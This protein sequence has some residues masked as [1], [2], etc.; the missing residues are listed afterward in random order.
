M[1]K[2]STNWFAVL[3]DE[4]VMLILDQTAN[5]EYYAMVPLVSK[6]LCNLSRDSFGRRKRL[7]RNRQRAPPRPL[8]PR[9]ESDTRF[10]LSPT[11]D[12]ALAHSTEYETWHRPIL[13]KTFPD[14]TRMATYHIRQMLRM[15][16]ENYC[17][18]VSAHLETSQSECAF[19]NKRA[20]YLDWLQTFLS[21]SRSHLIVELLHTADYAMHGWNSITNCPDTGRLF[22]NLFQSLFEQISTTDTAS[23]A[24]TMVEKPNMFMHT[25]VIIS[26]IIHIFPISKEELCKSPMFRAVRSSFPS[27]KSFLSFKE[28]RRHRVSDVARL[29]LRCFGNIGRFLEPYKPCIEYCDKWDLPNPIFTRLFNLACK[30]YGRDIELHPIF[31][32]EVLSKA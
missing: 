27:N 15:D 21:E 22:W 3:P 5:L 4:I 17:C 31:S 30:L 10:T 6:R 13:F 26:V 28:S 9:L 25:N 12:A 29:V 24:P 7:I 20:K 11:R 8:V 19:F 1:S 14:A 23:E 2:S 16:K 18:K 32:E